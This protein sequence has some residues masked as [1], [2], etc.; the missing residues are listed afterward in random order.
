MSYILD[1]LKKADAER[2]QG[3][4][5]GL[6]TPTANLEVDLPPLRGRPPA[7]VM[8]LGAVLV[9]AALGS[10]W[11]WTR[12]VATATP[13]LGP[14]QSDPQPVQAQALQTAQPPLAPTAT[15]SVTPAEPVPTQAL[16]PSVVATPT[17]LSAPPV[18]ASPMTP[19]P[20]RAQVVAPA[21]QAEVRPP[22]VTPPRTDAPVPAVAAA[23]PPARAPIHVDPAA[24]RAAPAQVPSLAELPDDVRRSLPAL[25]VSGAMYSDQP[26][27]RML[28]INNRV[29]HEGDQPVA[30]LVLEEIRL[31]SAVFRFQ[32]QRFSVNY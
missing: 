13:T 26:A 32:G 6:H 12:P 21:L 25:T 19:P 4:V 30:G 18:S 29:F 28:L 1:A 31:K 15:P 10:A 17:R 2:E 24:T 23:K 5:P 9:L 3:R 11:L 27:N 16:P 8:G 20:A 22:V 7:W 14:L